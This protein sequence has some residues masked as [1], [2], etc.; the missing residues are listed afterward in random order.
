[1]G[2]VDIVPEFNL[3][4]E[5]WP[6]YTNC[7]LNYPQ[8]ISKDAKVVRS[9][10]G[11]GSEIC[12]DIHNSVIGLDVKIG[13]GSVIRDSIIMRKSVIGDNVYM[14]KAII[15]ANT[16]VGSNVKIGVGEP[17]PN[18]VKPDIYTDGIA[19]VG[20]DAVIPDN[21]TIGKNTAIAGRT[22][23][24][25]YPGGCLPSGGFLQGEVDEE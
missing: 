22:T 13:K 9:I 12:G 1:M 25:D 11:G 3:Y 21:V 8:Y 20:E 10:I 6:I 23:A 5:Y 24:A 15:G 19:A 4:E 17:V 7:E 2:L 18:E 16:V 14:E